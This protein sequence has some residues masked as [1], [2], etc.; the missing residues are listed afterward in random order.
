MTQR[1]KSGKT[2]VQSFD[3]E[4]KLQTVTEGGQTTTFTYD[5]DGNRVKKVDP[6]GTTT[7]VGGYYEVQ[8]S[9]V[10]KYYT[11]THRYCAMSSCQA[12]AMRQGPAGQAGTVT[13]LHGDHLGST[14]LTT[15]A[16][17][18]KTA[19]VLYYPYGEERYREGTLQ[20][21]YQ[22]TSQ[23]KEGFGLY[24]YRA[25]F[26][27]PSLGRFTSADTIV[28][29]P[30][31]PQLFNRYSYAGNSPIVYNDPDGH[32]GPLCIIGIGL[33]L[34]GVSLVVTG[35]TPRPPE[36]VPCTEQGVIG[37]GLILG[38]TLL[39]L[40]PVIAGGGATAACADGDCINEG[41]MAVDTATRALEAASADGDPTNEISA[42]A[43]IFQTTT[44]KLQHVFT[45]HAKAF[46]ITENWN[47][48][49]GEKFN[50]V[51]LNH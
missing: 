10:T 33:V 45:R 48:A 38:G 12:V 13:Y 15:D 32:C 11:H 3:A 40:S 19:R 9:T 43:R 18:A 37:G 7:Y 26:Y 2:Y 4:N 30:G 17:G 47:K 5:G 16:N 8:G 50:Q 28:P 31:N 14:S 29:N 44:S 6:S 23:R 39:V 25:R 36:E 46:G 35:D 20:T 27:D 22:F 41:Q 21:D 42:S 51:L 34:V 49:A 24:D 1:I